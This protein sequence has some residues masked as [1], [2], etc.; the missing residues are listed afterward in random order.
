MLSVFLVQGYKGY[1]NAATDLDTFSV[2]GTLQGEYCALH[3]EQPIKVGSTMDPL[4]TNVVYKSK[5][6]D[7]LV[8]KN[9]RGE[10]KPKCRVTGTYYLSTYYMPNTQ[11][12]PTRC[13][14]GGTCLQFTGTCLDEDF[15]SGTTSQAQ[16]VCGPSY[17]C[18]NA[19]CAKGVIYQKLKIEQKDKIDPDEASTGTDSIN[20]CLSITSGGPI[21]PNDQDLKFQEAQPDNN[22][23]CGNKPDDKGITANDG[24]TLCY[25]TYWQDSGYLNVVGATDFSWLHAKNYLTERPL[26]IST[27]NASYEVL[28]DGERWHSCKPTAFSLPNSQNPY[29]LENGATITLPKEAF[30]SVEGQNFDFVA[31]PKGSQI[32]PLDL[33]ETYS[34]ETDCT[35]SDQDGYDTCDPN[36]DC[37]DSNALVYPGA[38]DIKDNLDN[39]CNGQDGFDDPKL[40]PRPSFICSATEKRSTFLECSGTDLES[41]KMNVPNAV[42][43]GAPSTIIEDFPCEA[44]NCGAK[45]LIS[46]LEE[47]FYSIIKIKNTATKIY[48][49][50]PYSALEFFVYFEDDF[51]ANIALA[52]NK[53]ETQS[54]LSDYNILFEEQITNYVTSDIGLKRWLKVSIPLSKL[55]S[56]NKIDAIIITANK[57]RSQEIGNM[58]SPSNSIIVDR[59]SLV[60]TTTNYC[61][62]VYSWI[63]DL[64]QNEMACNS[65]PSYRWTGTQCCGDDNSDTFIDTKGACWQG[66][67]IMDN[68]L[69]EASYS[70]NSQSFTKKC[71]S[72]PCRLPLPLSGP[73]SYKINYVP[74][75]FIATINLN[76][77]SLDPVPIT[78]TYQNG[79]ITLT[80]QE[81]N[82]LTDALSFSIEFFQLMWPSLKDTIPE[83]KLTNTVYSYS[84]SPSQMN[85]IYSQRI[86]NIVTGVETTAEYYRFTLNSISPNTYSP[87]RGSNEETAVANYFCQQISGGN[88][89]SWQPAGGIFVEPKSSQLTGSTILKIYM[90]GTLTC[91]D[92]SK[93]SSI[94]IQ[95]INMPEK[96]VKADSILYLGKISDLLPLP[97][98]H[99]LNYYNVSSSNSNVNLFFSDTKN[100][101]TSNKDA[102]LYASTNYY[103]TTQTGNSASQITITNNDPRTTLYLVSK[104]SKIPQ[105]PE[106]TLQSNSLFNEIEAKVP[107]VFLHDTGILW[108]CG[109]SD[110]Q[111]SLFDA[112]KIREATPCQVIKSFTCDP[113]AGWTNQFSADPATARTSVKVDP[114]TEKGACCA[115]D[116]CWTGEFCT[117][118]RQDVTEEPF[119]IQGQ[120]FKCFRGEWSEASETRSWFNE[121]GYCPQKGQCLVDINGDYTKN[122]MPENFVGLGKS[123]NPQCIGSN[124]VI[125]DHLC[126]NGNWTSRTKFI[127]VELLKFA[128][129]LPTQSYSM[130]C[131]TYDKALNVYEFPEKVRADIKDIVE[132]KEIAPRKRS[133]KDSYSTPCINNVCVMSYVEDETQKTAIGFSLN[134]DV[135]SDPSI[136]TVFGEK[137]DICKGALV[138]DDFNNCK[139]GKYWYKP[140][141]QVLIVSKNEGIFLRE[142]GFLDQFLSNPFKAVFDFVKNLFFKVPTPSGTQVP[143][144]VSFVQKFKD[145]NRVYVAKKDGKSVQA[146]IEKINETKEAM[147]IQYDGFETDFCKIINLYAAEK[148]AT[149]SCVKTLTPEGKKSVYIASEDPSF[150]IWSSMTGRLRIS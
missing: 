134:K 105:S 83:E 3:R 127:S 69:G 145:F 99:E 139:E 66:S 10:V 131:D 138:S 82:V 48:D 100:S 109:A 94:S 40:N 124:Q 28:S 67:P 12:T 2:Q 44:G 97:T 11:S 54:T 33:I 49:W 119:D 141:S 77:N 8:C 122:N 46:T 71:A 120:K 92:S 4:K 39:D 107:L 144:D 88:M 79:L 24:R 117:R 17:I 110:S 29:H 1:C 14:R 106:G 47:K 148:Q 135:S 115:S 75:N 130:Y 22:R 55:P 90:D 101:K 143:L 60:G 15:K 64:D 149:I 125:D 108:S 59:F 56:R 140:D 146:I 45:L 150:D 18:I 23:C 43:M 42:F 112:S 30:D 19:Y 13:P 7:T 52:Q 34:G 73:V 58:T 25:G 121:V 76:S 62:N 118:E 68:A 111:K 89:I 57:L 113:T 6:C 72:Y 70:I 114:V 129:N 91:A 27:D 78:K 98:N 132:G 41:S 26:T 93:S 123:G 61:T 74:V 102:T 147:I 85:F 103:E 36:P 116:A 133:C 35:D 16:C 142:P 63:T 65:N 51:E 31:Y 53:E 5:E 38:P 126:L 20:E 37:D 128:N 32:V 84:L 9:E 81:E 50:T 136:L 21:N 137:K 96:E 104:N 80:G 95:K 86:I 87:E